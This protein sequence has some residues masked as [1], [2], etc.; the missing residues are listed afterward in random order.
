MPTSQAS[1]PQQSPESAPKQHLTSTLLNKCGF[2]IVLTLSVSSL[3]WLLDFVGVCIA[4][5][6]QNQ[7][8][9]TINPLR[10]QWFFLAVYL[11]SIV[12]MIMVVLNGCIAVYRFPIIASIV[13]CIAFGVE[14]MDSGVITSQLSNG[15]SASAGGLRAAGVFCILAAMF[16][17][18]F[19]FG[20]EKGAVELP[21]FMLRVPNPIQKTDQGNSHLPS[22]NVN[23][24]APSHHHANSDRQSMSTQ[25]VPL[26]I[27]QSTTPNNGVVPPPKSG[28]HPSSFIEIPMSDQ[29]RV[30]GP[31]PDSDMSVGSNLN[32]GVYMHRVK[33]VYSY[34]ANP[35]D[36]TELTFEKGDTLEVVDIQ[37]KWWQA[38]QVKAD[39]QTNIGIVPSNY[40]QVI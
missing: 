27:L 23:A 1:Y 5:Q 12:G 6:Q 21:P 24:S 31:R 33:A 30:G 17:N 3:G 38:R 35:E 13:L 32:N 8:V 36:P 22:H 18:V 10:F 14:D 2:P 4:Q 9:Y 11:V 37:G 7:F 19:L 39:G 25:H 40:M 34:K 29:K 16:I 26:T 20:V 15:I 28:E